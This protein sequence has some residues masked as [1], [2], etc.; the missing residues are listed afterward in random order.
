[1]THKRLL[2]FRYALQGIFSAA[3]H[4][5][6]LKIQ[7]LAAIL[8]F[9]LAMLLEASPTEWL[10]IMIC[11]GLVIS[12]EMINTAIEKTIDLISPEF[13]Q[14]AGLIKDI[15]AGAVLIA[16]FFSL[17]CGLIIFIPKII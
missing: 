3:R 4:Q 12:L 10:V 11:S 15:S 17:I 13:S 2:S 6:N 8:A 5:A 9:L 16:A 7:I 14:Q 1:M